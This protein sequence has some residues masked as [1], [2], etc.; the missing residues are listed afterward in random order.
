M[1]ITR[2]LVEDYFDRN[3]LNEEYVEEGWLGGLLGFIAGSP[4]TA[5][6]ISLASGG[7]GV[8]AALTALGVGAAGNISTSA[9][10]HWLEEWWRYKK[11]VVAT[12]CQSTEPGVKR[13]MCVVNGLEK[14]INEL[15]SQANKLKPG[16][17][18]WRYMN[19]RINKYQKDLDKFKYRVRKVAKKVESD[20]SDKDE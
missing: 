7:V 1:K 16:S 20:K 19:R 14:M 5:L 4:L 3:A 18:E 11:A 17:P 15:A 12:G 10:G 6:G 8:P 13:S 9:L 2:I